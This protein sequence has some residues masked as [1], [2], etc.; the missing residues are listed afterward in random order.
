MEN[1]NFDKRTAVFGGS[2][3]PPTKGHLSIVAQTLSYRRAESAAHFFDEVWVLPSGG[4]RHDK[5]IGSPASWRLQ[6]LEQALKDLDQSL[7]LTEDGKSERIRIVRDETSLSHF[8]PTATLFKKW[9]AEAPKTDFWLVIGTDQLSILHTWREADYIFDRVPIFCL[10]RSLTPDAAAIGQETAALKDEGHGEAGDSTGEG[11]REPRRIIRACHLISHGACSTEARRRIEELRLK[12][13][14]GNA[15]RD[16][17]YRLALY[18]LLSRGVISLIL[19]K[20]VEHQDLK[21][22]SEA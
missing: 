22:S 18:P 11:R 20:A 8:V 6:M 15:D 10:P 4:S 7:S 2:F 17:Q 3:D 12:R 21:N 16:I 9:R 14:S 5:S 1:D 13:F 19:S